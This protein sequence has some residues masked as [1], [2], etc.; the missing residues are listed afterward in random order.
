MLRQQIA[1]VVEQ[2]PDDELLR[3][4][5]CA[6]RYAACTTRTRR[7]MALMCRSCLLEELARR[8]VAAESRIAR[9]GS[10]DLHADGA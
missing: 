3:E 10:I 4:L 7:D 8:Q 2:L 9:L 1:R 6:Q 5:R